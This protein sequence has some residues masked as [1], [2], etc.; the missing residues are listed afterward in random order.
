MCLQD[1][2]L[3]KVPQLQLHRV[4]QILFHLH[5]IELKVISLSLE[6]PRVDLR[7]R[8]WAKFL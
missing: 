6:L 4:L 7:P 1:L 3:H 5:R 8:I 2:R